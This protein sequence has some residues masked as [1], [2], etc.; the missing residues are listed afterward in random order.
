MFQRAFEG[1]LARD[2]SRQPNSSR[3]KALGDRHRRA[4]IRKHCR[5]EREVLL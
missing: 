2:I 5:F 1:R 3:I 4:F